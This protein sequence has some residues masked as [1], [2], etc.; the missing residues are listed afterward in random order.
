MLTNYTATSLDTMTARDI[1]ELSAPV[2]KALQDE[3]AADE[4]RTKA[5]KARL[6]EGLALRYTDAAKA[7]LNGKDHGTAHVMDGG[8]DVEAVFKKTVEWEDAALRDA[9][10]KMEP[11]D[12]ARYAKVKITVGEKEYTIAP[13]HIRALLDQARTVK[14]SAP[15]FKLNVKE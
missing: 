12:Q 11:A 7:A 1:A 6:A 2:L 3:L 8:V 14:T 13:T 9:L 5:R 10:G 15:T 4:T